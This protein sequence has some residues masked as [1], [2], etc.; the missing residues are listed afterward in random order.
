MKRF[1][2]FVFIGVFLLFAM[3]SVIGAVL[4]NAPENSLT[5]N[6]SN[7]TPLHSFQVVVSTRNIN[8]GGTDADVYIEIAGVSYLM[9]KPGYNDFEKGD[10]DKYS[11]GFRNAITM[12][13][14]RKCQIRLWHN[15][16][17]SNPGWFC[18]KVDLSI[19]PKNNPNARLYKSW[20]NI[21]WLA[22]DE[23]DNGYLCEAILQLGVDDSKK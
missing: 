12:G 7:E 1:F 9:D 6:Y 5:K 22:K 10:T 18:Q 16:R 11:F 17:G 13:E 8:Y 4:H 15:N 19:I 14:F 20:S 2:H 3:S 21:G 23:P